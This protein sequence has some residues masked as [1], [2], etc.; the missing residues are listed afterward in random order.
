VLSD[1]VT[2]LFAKSQSLSSRQNIVLP[3]TGSKPIKLC[4]LLSMMFEP[5]F[6]PIDPLP[7][8]HPFSSTIFF[9]KD[10]GLFL[11]GSKKQTNYCLPP[12]LIIAAR[13]KKTQLIFQWENPFGS[14]PKNVGF[15][16]IYTCPHGIPLQPSRSEKK[17]GKKQKK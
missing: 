7:D 10:V 6:G 15:F 12:L 13:Q 17:G 16:P 14:P 2:E 9:V 5:F 8:V 4:Y 11:S 1:K 3:A